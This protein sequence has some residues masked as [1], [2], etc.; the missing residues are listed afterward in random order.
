MINDYDSDN[1]DHYDDDI[2][3]TTTSSCS[4]SSSYMPKMCL[5]YISTFSPLLWAQ[6]ICKYYP[7]P[8]GHRFISIDFLIE[9]NVVSGTWMLLTLFR[10]VVQDNNR[11][12]LKI[13]F[14]KHLQKSHA[15]NIYRDTQVTPNGLRITHQLYFERQETELGITWHLK[16][17]STCMNLDIISMHWCSYFDDCMITILIIFLFCFCYNF[18]RA[19]L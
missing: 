17:D 15:L 5:F 19:P 4:C 11:S 2:T 6:T 12:G 13:T 14:L 18:T 9:F 10:P 3:T 16:N 1:N 8:L 7:F